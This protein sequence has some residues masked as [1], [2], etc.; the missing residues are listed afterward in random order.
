MS[1]ASEVIQKFKKLKHIK[2]KDN[3]FLPVTG[4]SRRTYV[5]F[6]ERRAGVVY[7]VW[8]QANGAFAQLRGSLRSKM[9]RTLTSDISN[10]MCIGT[11]AGYFGIHGGETVSFRNTTDDVVK[12][13]IEQLSKLYQNFEKIISSSVL[14]NKKQKVAHSEAM[15][16]QT[17]VK[18]VKIQNANKDGEC[19]YEDWAYDKSFLNLSYDGRFERITGLT[20][21][22]WVGRSYADTK[23]LVIGESNYGATEGACRKIDADK[24]FVRKVVDRICIKKVESNA[25][26]A[27]IARIL[28]T[29]KDVKSKSTVSDVWQRIAY[30]DMCQSSVLMKI[31]P[32]PENFRAGVDP[33]CLT[34]GCLKPHFVIFVGTTARGYIKNFQ[35]EKTEKTECNFK[36]KKTGRIRHVV[37]TQIY[38]SLKSEVGDA[39]TP[40]V[41]INHPAR[42]G[43]STKRSKRFIKESLAENLYCQEM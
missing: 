17:K 24:L 9:Y 3:V 32:S 13:L 2:V 18:N 28:M 34:I 40:V 10:G 29:K 11:A 8:C 27:R 16:S 30:M 7:E 35:E 31:P 42:P 33:V 21:L 6:G 26:F 15:H 1:S 39:N 38:G 20:W 5:H 12:K 19:W 25:T 22:P 43:A 36:C 23:I 41:F 4:S 14:A 37:L